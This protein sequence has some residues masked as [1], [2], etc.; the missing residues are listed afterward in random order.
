M[1]F[2][3]FYGEGKPHGGMDDYGGVYNTLDEAKN[4]VPGTDAEWGQIAVVR[5]GTLVPKYRMV[6][7]EEELPPVD[8]SS[9]MDAFATLPQHLRA[10]AFVE[11]NVAGTAIPSRRYRIVGYDWQ[12]VLED[13]E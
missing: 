2:H 10:N 6:P 11:F 5:G 4:A 1:T 9:A 8:Y 12:E 3:V 7:I 13:D